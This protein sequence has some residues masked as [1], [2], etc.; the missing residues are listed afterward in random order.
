MKPP[1][2]LPPFGTFTRVPN[3]FVSW[4]FPHLTNHASALWIYLW[5]RYRWKT[6][7]PVF[8]SIRAMQRAVNMSAGVIQKSLEELTALDLVEVHAPKSRRSAQSYSIP[9]YTPDEA[10]LRFRKP[11]KRVFRKNAHTC[12]SECRTQ[13]PQLCADSPNTIQ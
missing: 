5:S 12:V 13:T 9:A 11:S 4:C 3:W 1:Y 8:V 7:V 6:K 2:E 10:R